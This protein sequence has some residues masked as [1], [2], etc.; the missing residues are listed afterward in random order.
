MNETYLVTPQTSSQIQEMAMASLPVENDLQQKRA[1]SYALTNAFGF[2][3]YGVAAFVSLVLLNIK[4][5]LQLITASKN[6][7]I[8][9]VLGQINMQLRMYG[10]SQLV[11]WLTIIIFWGA[12]GLGVYTLFWLGTAFFTTARNE[13]IVET[14]FSNR[15]H[16]QERIRV[17]IIKLLLLLGA[18]AMVFVTVKWSA[19]FLSNLFMKGVYLILTQTMMGILQIFLATIVAFINIYIFRLLVVYFRHADAIF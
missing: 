8:D 17:P 14:A 19:P 10:D 9:T 2:V 15:G 1:K 13:L 6:N 5:I 18:L 3:I 4:S 7:S 12:V 16:F 11:N